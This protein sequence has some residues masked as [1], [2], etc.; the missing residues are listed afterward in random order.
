MQ[1]R[2]DPVIKLVTNSASAQSWSMDGLP[3]P[4][5]LWVRPASGNTF[6]VEY[7]TDGG[8]NYQS[9]SALTGATAYA[10]TIVSSGFTNIRITPS[11]TQGGEWGYA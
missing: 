6:T 10:E 5:T 4:A 9:L 8:R 11:G 7:S 1:Y 3:I 2:S